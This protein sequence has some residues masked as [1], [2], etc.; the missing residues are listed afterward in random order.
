MKIMYMFRILAA[1]ILIFLP[2]FSVSK[3]VSKNSK[4]LAL[5]KQCEDPAQWHAPAIIKFLKTAVISRIEPMKTYLEKQ[6]KKAEFEGKV[7]V[8]TFNNGTKGVFKAMLDDDNGDILC[9]AIAYKASTV[10]GFPYIPPHY[11][12][13]NSLQ[14][15]VH[16]RRTLAFC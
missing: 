2:A 12:Q 16:K 13:R 15:Q 5:Q 4:D 14:G 8:V 7:F 3:A 11:L 9:E 10:L 1:F 6:G